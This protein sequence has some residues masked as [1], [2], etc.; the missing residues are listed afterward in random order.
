[1]TEQE[2][3]SLSADQLRNMDL[4]EEELNKIPIGKRIKALKDYSQPVRFGS[5]LWNILCISKNAALIM[6][7]TLVERISYGGTEAFTEREFSEEERK[8]IK[9]NYYGRALISLDKY[10]IERYLDQSERKVG[11]HWWIKPE[12]AGERTSDRKECVNSEGEFDYTYEE[13]NL[14][15]RP[16][17]WIEIPYDERDLQWNQM[18]ERANVQEITFKGQWKAKKDHRPETVNLHPVAQVYTREET[19]QETEWSIIPIIDCS[20]I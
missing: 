16:V 19:R 15:V 14:C 8:A 20:D 12:F 13:T 11:R 5:D 3:M 6:A 17:A 1:M 18:W 9:L 2:I 4:S 10:Q 7:Q